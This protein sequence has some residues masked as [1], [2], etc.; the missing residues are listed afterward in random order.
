MLWVYVVYENVAGPIKTHNKS[1]L[2]VLII[3]M[4]RV[5]KGLSLNINK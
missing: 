3:E 2:D 1:W 4:Y 5:Y